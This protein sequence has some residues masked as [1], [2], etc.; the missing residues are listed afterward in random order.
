MIA[1]KNKE[2][3]FI[4]MDENK[5]VDG[6]L[7]SGVIGKILITFLIIFVISTIID[8]L[9]NNR[10]LTAI[11]GMLENQA[12][13]DVLKKCI[14][15]NYD[16]AE[17]QWRETKLIIGKTLEDNGVSFPNDLN[18]AFQKYDIKREEI[19]DCLIFPEDLN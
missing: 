18:T 2:E 1:G 10:V 4:L 5:V 7:K 9:E 11:E 14:K 15:Q 17:Q 6:F 16:I 8:K 12:K 3:E 19:K 13:I